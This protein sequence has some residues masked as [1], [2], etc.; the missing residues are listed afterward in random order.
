MRYIVYSQSEKPVKVKLE[1]RSILRSSLKWMMKNLNSKYVDFLSNCG[2][3]KSDKTLRY[4]CFSDLNAKPRNIKN[5]SFN[6]VEEISFQISIPADKQ[7][8]H[9]LTNI[10]RDKRFTLGAR[11]KAFQVV[12]VDS[13]EEAEISNTEDFVCL[14]PIAVSIKDKSRRHYLSC[15]KTEECEKLA[16]K[17]HENLIRKYVSIHGE[18][19]T[20]KEKFK[21]T[22]DEDFINEMNGC[23]HKNVPFL[24]YSI[25]VNFAPFRVEG[26]PELI[27]IGYNY[28]FGMHNSYG[29][30]MVEKK[31]NYN[32]ITEYEPDAEQ[33]AK[34]SSKK[35]GMRNK[36]DYKR[37]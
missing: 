2:V 20:S 1:N 25:L 6:N 19:Y 16:V 37:R 13:M 10:F 35:S 27:K 32:P 14:S 12:D 22:F 28:G 33:K 4:F 7:L 26:D 24:K 21:M 5:K 31:G 30:G 34:H 3:Y 17:I 15:S 36:R 9:M 11:D 18:S 29:F 23:A 8:K